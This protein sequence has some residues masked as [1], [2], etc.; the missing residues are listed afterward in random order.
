MTPIAAMAEA[1][2]TNGEQSDRLGRGALWGTNRGRFNGSREKLC[3]F[4]R[5][6]DAKCHSV[7]CTW[8]RYGS[9]NVLEVNQIAG[10][11]SIIHHPDHNRPNSRFWSTHCAA[12]VIRH[13]SRYLIQLQPYTQ[14]STVPSNNGTP[15]Q[16]LA[17]TV[18]RW[19][20]RSQTKLTRP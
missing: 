10:T 7:E 8:D 19:Q 17:T 1:S 6:R 15:K 14:C 20:S 13:R 9:R 11:P 2:R 5:G 18:F 16:W 3:G 4:D 12:R